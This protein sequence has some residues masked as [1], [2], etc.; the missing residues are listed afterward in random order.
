MNMTTGISWTNATVNPI[1]YRDK[2]GK[3]VW[4]CV[5]HSPGCANCY[6]E[7]LAFQYGRG[8]PFTRKTMEGLEAYVCPKEIM[9]ILTA[10]GIAG[11]RVF[12]GDMTDIF[13]D[14]IEDELLDRVFAAMAI[15][16]DVTFQVLTKRADRMA[17]YVGDLV[18]GERRLGDALQEIG[19]E[20]IVGRLLLASAFGVKVGDEGKP[21]YQPFSNVWLGVSA[22]RQKEA[23]ER[24]PHLLRTPA[25]VRFVSYE[26]A[27][28]PIDFTR[29]WMADGSGF[30]NALDGRLTAKMTGV[31]GNPDG[32]VE[33]IEPITGHVSQVIFGGESGSN[34]RPMQVDWVSSVV[35]L[36]KAAG[37][38]VFVKQ[39][40]GNKPGQQGRIPLEIWQH[41]EQPA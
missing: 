8:G 20:G 21:P 4:A 33:T 40:S 5:K 12:L 35:A 13:G 11:K 19:R 18:N 30:W 6:A 25:A 26:P 2:N 14:W 10:K 34:H 3:V 23:D 24:I 22:E 39:D 31:N 27:L 7:R 15:R 9:S 41:K 36:C 28:G 37:V 29:L 32:W 16:S 1:K 38:S 17:K